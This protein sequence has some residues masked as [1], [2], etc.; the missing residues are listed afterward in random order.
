MFPGL[1]SHD[2]KKNNHY[3]IIKNRKENKQKRKKNPA[4]VHKAQ[5]DCRLPSTPPL[6][7][8]HL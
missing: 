8:V 4:K 5:K 7:N 2:N 1:T 6:A 3:H